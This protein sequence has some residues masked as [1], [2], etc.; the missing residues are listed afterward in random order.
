MKI[1]KPHEYV[2]IFIQIEVVLTDQVSPVVERSLTDWKVGGSIL[3]LFAS[4]Q[5][6]NKQHFTLYQDTSG[7]K[8]VSG[9]FKLYERKN[10]WR[11]FKASSNNSEFTRRTKK[12]I[13]L[14]SRNSSDLDLQGMRT[15][16]FSS[17]S[18][19]V[20]PCRPKV[21]SNGCYQTVTF[22]LHIT[23]RNSCSQ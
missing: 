1:L 10:L 7:Y 22:I 11:A 5:A 16:L 23:Y 20:Y 17:L 18:S 14:A 3:H 8:Y 9:T 21:F 6:R 15:L 13:N 2:E 4:A 12:D 19:W